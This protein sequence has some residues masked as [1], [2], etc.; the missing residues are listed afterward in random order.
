MFYS[1]SPVADYVAAASQVVDDAVETACSSGH[2]I[3]E[4]RYQLPANMTID[5]LPKDVKL[6]GDKLSYSATY[7]F[8]EQVLTVKRVFDDRTVG[9]VCTPAHAQAYKDFAAQAVPDS[10][11]Q[12][13]FK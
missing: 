8:K 1:E 2:S 7:Q 12:V 4:Y 11:V 13:V 9:N 6:D 5:Q 3:E 10:T